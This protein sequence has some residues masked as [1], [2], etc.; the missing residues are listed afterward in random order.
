MLK[1]IYSTAFKTYNN[2][3]RESIKFN[4]GLNVVLGT[5]DGKNS[6]G[7]SSFLMVL[8]FVFGGD[9]Y[10]NKCPDIQENVKGHVICFAFENDGVISK[11]SRS[12]LSPNMVS[13]CDENYKELESISIT[14]YRDLLADMYGA[15][16]KLQ[17]FR[18][19]VSN[20]IRVY[21]RENCDEKHPIEVARKG[22]E[23]DA[24]FELIKLFGKYDL[25]EELRQEEKRLTE[26]KA[27]YSKAI[28]NELIPKVTKTQ[29]KANLKRIQALEDELASIKISNDI[30]RLE[31]IGVSK[32]N[33]DEIGEAK[34]AVILARRKYSKLRS[35][36]R[37]ICN[38]TSD[39]VIRFDDDI[40]L[41]KEYFPDVDFKKISEIEA[42]HEKLEG[43]LNAEIEEAKSE[44][45][46]LIE[47]AKQEKEL[48]EQKLSE[49]SK[50]D[51]L[52]EKLVSK[53]VEIQAELINLKRA[54]D[55]KDKV[56]MY[57]DNLKDNGARSEVVIHGQL[58]VIQRDINLEM[59]ELNNSIYKGTMSAPI[60]T[61]SDDGKT[62]TF[63]TPN[64]SGTGT[65]CRGLILFD[66]AITKL[67]G[68]P[69]LIHDSVIHKQIEDFALNKLLDL[70]QESGSQVFIA[71]DK[72]DSYGKEVE[73]K[74]ED[75]KILQLSGNGNELYGRPWN[76]AK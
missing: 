41:L 18:G 23:D 4:P 47:E 21:Q 36:Y 38:N 70:Y 8:D 25:V 45:K 66:L 13:V 6:I 58:E 68:L 48:A 63:R 34:N 52:S 26:L 75:A 43:I 57:D 39:R 1:E 56:E 29:Y 62:Y 44:L 14:K 15:K 59:A 67:T 32:D 20:Y 30:Q 55:A 10:I 16:D 19:M 42:F 65:S 24:I 7:K 69:I 11:F 61:F 72:Q 33:I 3:I 22:K 5:K 28:K 2:E 40:E 35:E 49:L 51:N 76:V 27:T 54:N 60:I 37:A 73:E 74:L 64:D 46:R 53:V 71:L 31:L 12:T 9:D 17:K 50:V